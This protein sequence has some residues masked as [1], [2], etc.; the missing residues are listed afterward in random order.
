MNLLGGR[1]CGAWWAQLAA[2]WRLRPR[3]GKSPRS[4]WAGVGAVA[5]KRSLAA[6]PS[7][8]A[9]DLLSKM[10]QHDPAKRPRIA[11]VL[12]HPFFAGDDEKYALLC[13][14][15][16]DRLRGAPKPKRRERER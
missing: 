9:R 3:K 1:G 13:R 4:V 2:A 14:V 12:A 5:L 15:F 10:L 8:E 6:L 16:N 7:A 11:Q